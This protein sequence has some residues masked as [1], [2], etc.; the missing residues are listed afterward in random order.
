MVN[1]FKIRLILEKSP[2][3]SSHC[4]IFSHGNSVSNM[5]L[6]VINNYSTPELDV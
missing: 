3:K 4:H 1:S 6:N 2:L 5:F